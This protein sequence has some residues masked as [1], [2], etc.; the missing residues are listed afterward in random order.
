M[1]VLKYGIA[2][3]YVF[4][5]HFSSLL[6]YCPFKA[7]TACLAEVFLVKALAISLYLFHSLPP[8]FC[9]FKCVPVCIQAWH[10][11]TISPFR[12]HFYSLA[13]VPLNMSLPVLP[14]FIFRHGIEQFY[15]FIPQSLLLS[16]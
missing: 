2:Q 12:S 13:S 1:C 8:S 6:C 4:M 15:V 3:N 7:G 14:V 11:M 9:P 16:L 5:P 10:C